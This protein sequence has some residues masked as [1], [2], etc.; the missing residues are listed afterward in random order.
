[1]MVM[2]LADYDGDRLVGKRTLVLA[3]GPRR[4]TRAYAVGQW[5]AYGSLPLLVA[6]GMPAAVAGAIALTLPL[7]VW[8]ARRLLRGA[9]ADPRTGNNVVFWASTHVALVVV[10]T[11]VGVFVHL[12]AGATVGGLTH[13][14]PSALLL[15][16]PLGYLAV[17]GP[18][19][20]KNRTVR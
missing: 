9:Y 18:Q 12:L 17:V 5:V 11:S 16:V 7:S 2:N 14:P 8:Q 13:L 10:A 6:A 20:W 4:A 15:L 3:L 19:I 1:M